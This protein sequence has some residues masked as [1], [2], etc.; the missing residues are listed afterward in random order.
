MPGERGRLKIGRAVRVSAVSGS[1][2]VTDASADRC[3][4]ASSLG[5]QK[6][7]AA[8]TRRAGKQES[9]GYRYAQ[10]SVGTAA[11]GRAAVPELS[12]QRH[13]RYGSSPRAR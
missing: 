5:V 13:P 3:F 2:S 11:C 10:K 4:N 9:T 12:E 7:S 6:R 8:E 1:V